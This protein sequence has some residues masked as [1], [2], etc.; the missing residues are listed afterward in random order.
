MPFLNAQSGKNGGRERPSVQ[1]NKRINLLTAQNEI[2]AELGQSKA[3]LLTI[4]LI[5]GFVIFHMLG[6]GPSLISVENTKTVLKFYAFY[7]VFAAICWLHMKFKPGNY[8]LRRLTTMIGDYS[9]LVYTMIICGI[10]GMALFGTVLW[11]TLGNG[12]RFGRTYLIIAIVMAEASVLALMILSPVWRAQPELII[13][14]MFMML[15]IPAYSSSLLKQTAEARDAA[16]EA[17]LAKSRFLAQ[18]SHDLRQPIHAIGYYLEGL[19]TTNLDD[20]QDRVVDKI[21]RGLNSV[22]RLF[23]SLLDISKLDSNSLSSNPEPVALGD[24]LSDLVHQNSEMAHWKNVELRYVQ[25]SQTVIVDPVLLTTMVQNLLSNALKYSAGKKVLLGVRQCTDTVAIEVHDNGPG[26]EESHLPFVF[27][28]FYRAHELGDKDIEGVG[29]GLAIVKRLAQLCD[30]DAKIRSRRGFGTSA[31][32][33]GLTRSSIRAANSKARSRNPCSPLLGLRVILIEDDVDVLEATESLLRSWGCNVQAYEHIP[34]IVRP[35]DLIVTDFDLGGGQTG[36][37]AIVRVRQKLDRDLPAIIM[38]GH[39]FL[40]V[41]AA[42]TAPA[43]NVLSK[44]LQPAAFR[45]CLAAIR[46][47]GLENA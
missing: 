9:A 10:P 37:D 34:S 4:P 12:M 40:R 43:I 36:L 19:R 8:P 27:D 38:T 15:A 42:I 22:A 31:S 18:A 2:G 17:M 41:R 25:T 30:I 39:D 24:L 1:S 45:S 35:A 14:L 33:T 46:L 29:L 47:S 20:N 44:P 7:S 23:K 13:M 21:E 3:R 32:I 6:F 26:I 16:T 5:T 28:E 11:V